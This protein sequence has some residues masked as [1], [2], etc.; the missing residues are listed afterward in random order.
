MDFF[1]NDILEEMIKTEK[2]K[3][4]RYNEKIEKDSTKFVEIDNEYEGNLKAISWQLPELDRKAIEVFKEEFDCT[5]QEIV[6]NALRF[7]VDEIF[8]RH[9]KERMDTIKRQTEEKKKFWDV[10]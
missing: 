7:Y 4:A 5:Y 8:Y 2:R 10:E 3:I 1:E 9:A 6:K